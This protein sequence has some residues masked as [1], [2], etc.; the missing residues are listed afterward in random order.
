M[1]LINEWQSQRYILIFIW[2]CSSH[3]VRVNYKK[4]LS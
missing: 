2:E 4:A 1:S 3:L